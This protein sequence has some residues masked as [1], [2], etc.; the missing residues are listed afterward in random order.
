ME[1]EIEL[2]K[3]SYEQLESKAKVIIDKLSD[4]D[5]NL[6][7]DESTQLFI[8]G[9]KITSLMEKKLKEAEDKVKDLIHD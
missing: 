2:E 4:S 7:L 5:S 6:S 9:K 8:L 3:M 1:K